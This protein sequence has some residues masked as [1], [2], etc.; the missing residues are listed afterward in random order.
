MQMGENMCKTGEMAQGRRTRGGC[1]EVEVEVDDR[2]KKEIRIEQ[3]S[4]K[5]K[6]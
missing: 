3:K 1:S 2:K 6:A 5:R 4:K